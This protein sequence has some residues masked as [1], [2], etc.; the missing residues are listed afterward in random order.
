V[1]VRSISTEPLDAKTESSHECPPTWNF[2]LPLNKLIFGGLTATAAVA[3]TAL[4]SGASE[5]RERQ[6]RDTHEYERPRHGL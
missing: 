5:R 6:D 2:A 1:V 4:A 3:G